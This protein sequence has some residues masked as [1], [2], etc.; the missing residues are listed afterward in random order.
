MLHKEGMVRSKT[1]F[2]EQAVRL[3]SSGTSNTV[4]PSGPVQLMYQLPSL[5]YGCMS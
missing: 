5:K 3:V 1:A 2:N 4:Y